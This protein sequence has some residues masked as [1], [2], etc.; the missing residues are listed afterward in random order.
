M[1]KSGYRAFQKINYLCI[2]LIRQFYDEPRSFRIMG[3]QGVEQFALFDNRRLRPVR[4]EGVFG[5][6][7]GF[8]RPVFDI[9][10]VSQK[11][12]PFNTIAQNE[13]AKELF[14]MGFFNPQL[15]DQALCAVEL[16]DF[17]GKE[18]VRQ[19]ITQNGTLLQMVQQMQAQ[20][21]KMAL[22]IDAQNG[23]SVSG[24]LAGAGPEIGRPAA[25]SADGTEAAM[26][27]VGRESLSSTAGKARVKAAGAAVPR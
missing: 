10:V 9:E 15:S 11:A 7:T 1:N 16:M 22:I 6:D 25:S 5:V 27:A 18:M 3:G 17:E 21:Q 8:R 4:Q 26:D 23:T 14:S 2:E 20:M 13:L 24:E 12:S 19:K